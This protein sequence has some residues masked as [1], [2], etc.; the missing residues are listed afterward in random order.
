MSYKSFLT[1]FLLLLAVPG[2]WPAGAEEHLLTLD[3][4]ASKVSFHLGASLH[5]V[6]GLLLLESGELRFDLESGIASGE[7]VIDATRTETG[8]GKR[9]RAMH[10]KVLESEA[11]PRIVFHLRRVSRSGPPTDGVLKLDLQ[12]V[13]A[14][15]GG[16]HEVSMAAEVK[17]EGDRVEGS[18]TLTV[19]YVA[20]GMHDP[21]L[22]FLRVAKEVEVTIEAT[23]THS[24]V[25]ESSSVGEE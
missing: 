4:E 20:W 19:P 22:L 13:V 12:G 6:E 25:S 16:E 5:D 24:L 17:L 9:D 10:K 7:I 21:S 11:F 23:G 3:P 14:I 18:A 2:A 15:H 8:N 1:I